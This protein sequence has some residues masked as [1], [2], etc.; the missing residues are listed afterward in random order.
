MFSNTVPCKKGNQSG[1]RKYYDLPNRLDKTSYEN[2]LL[3]ETQ[4]PKLMVSS[5]SLLKV[6]I[7]GYL[8]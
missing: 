1:G 2:T 7:G 3:I 5:L 4:L 8:C 6:S